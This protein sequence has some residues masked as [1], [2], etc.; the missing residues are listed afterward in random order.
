MDGS[1]SVGEENFALAMNFLKNVTNLMDIGPSTTIFRW[2][3]LRVNTSAA[4]K[5]SNS[6][7]RG[8]RV[9]M[10]QFSMQHRVEFQFIGDAEQLNAAFD[11]TQLLH[12]STFAGT[13][14]QFAVDNVYRAL[15]NYGFLV[16]K[17]K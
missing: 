17:W 10:T 14:I 8:F 4:H 13:A 7:H 15:V 11:S 5:I 6:F 12:G 9:A 3:E 2:G 16:G 1:S